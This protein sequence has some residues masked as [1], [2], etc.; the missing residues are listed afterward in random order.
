MRTN[1]GSSS[2]TAANA[3]AAATTADAAPLP[4]EPCGG[5]EAAPAGT[6]PSWALVVAPPALALPAGAS[7]GHGASCAGTHAARLHSTA[8]ACSGV[9]GAV[10]SGVRPL[11]PCPPPAAPA[12]WRPRR[13]PAPPPPRS[14]RPARPAAP[15]APARVW[16]G[17]LRLLRARSTAGC[18]RRGDVA[19]SGSAP[20][21]TAWARASARQASMPHAWGMAPVS[22]GR[23]PRT[24]DRVDVAPAAS[25]RSAAMRSEG[26]VTTLVRTA[27]AGGRCTRL[28]SKGRPSALA[29]AAALRRA[30]ASNRSSSATTAS[31][32]ESMTRG[33]GRRAARGSTRTLSPSAAATAATAATTAVGPGAAG[34]SAVA[35]GLCPDGAPVLGA[36]GAL[37]SRRRRR[38]IVVHGRP[39]G[40]PPLA[41]GRRAAAPSLSEGHRVRVTNTPRRAQ[42]KDVGPGRGT[43]VSG[44]QRRAVEAV[45]VAVSPAHACPRVTHW[46]GHAGVKRSR[47]GI[48][49]GETLLRR[50]R[51]EDTACRASGPVASAGSCARAARA[52]AS[53]SALG[54]SRRPRDSRR[55]PRHHAPQ[56]PS[57]CRVRQRRPQRR[58]HATSSRS[59]RPAQ[60]SPAQS[61]L[62]HADPPRRV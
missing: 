6:A 4:D 36:A 34:P 37:L 45:V 13:P 27:T 55:A 2:R 40:K 24:S 12:G 30:S 60:R 28:G 5:G 7:L 49:R 20:S 44:A 51:P 26:A 33:A 9:R 59:A 38:H 48:E 42:R 56:Q 14:A 19:R 8:A 46:T 25:D 50:C 41:I 23:W 11:R 1:A 31:A 10:A 35:S 16:N 29:A 57:A 17:A 61:S 47:H 3:L 18:Q 54:F 15:L 22:A 53:R 58:G 43:H 52:A 62:W 39:A 32:P 21:S